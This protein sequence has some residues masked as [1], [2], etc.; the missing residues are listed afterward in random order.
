MS[1]PLIFTYHHPH[2]G[3]MTAVILRKKGYYGN[4]RIALELVDVE[5]YCPFATVTVNVPEIEI[6]K[7]EI[8]VKS[9]AENQGML[10]FLVTNQICAAPRAIVE[11][12][13]VEFFICKLLI[14]IA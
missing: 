3:G 12:G 7:D 8:I 9:Y 10:N 2:D 13:H 6:G 14:K 1:E 5:D 4:G 11:R